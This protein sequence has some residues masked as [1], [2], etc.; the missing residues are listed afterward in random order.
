MEKKDMKSTT[1]LFMTSI[2]LIF[3]CGNRGEETE[4]GNNDS[5]HTIQ[6]TVQIPGVLI[7]PTGDTVKVPPETDVILYYWLPIDKH[8]EMQSDLLFLAS[9]DTSCVVLPIQPDHNS[10]NHAQRVINNMGISLP[11]YLADSIAMEIMKTDILPYCLILTP[12]DNEFTE[13][14]FGSPSRLLTSI[15]G[16]E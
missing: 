7:A 5:T 6:L 13:N 10:R 4:F 15:R 16:V 11:V 1:F 14:G 3:S 8:S 12:E 2:V 9:L